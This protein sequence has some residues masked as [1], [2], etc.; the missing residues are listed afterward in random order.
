MSLRSVLPLL[1]L[2]ACAPSLYGGAA[3][4]DDDDSADDD[5][6]AGGFDDDD[7]D[8]EPNWFPVPFEIAWT[9]DILLADLAFDTLESEGYLHPFDHLWDL[10]AADFLIGNLEGPIT[11][12][13]DPYYPDQTWSYN[14]LPPAAGALA[15][16]GFDALSLANN[17]LMDRGP[18]GV[19]DTREHLLDAGL[20]PFGAGSN[21]EESSEPLLVSTP[22]GIVGV[23]GMCE[24]TAF[25]PQAGPLNTGAH[26]FSLSRIQRSWDKAIE[27]GADYVVA[28][29][30]WG[31]NYDV[32]ESVQRSRAQVF[33]DVGYDLVV[34]HGAHVPQEVD[35]VGDMVVLYSLG[36][37]T[38]GTPGRFDSAYPGYGLVA[39]TT[40]GVD[41]FESIEL[42]CIL[43]D[44]GRVHF[45]PEP[46]PIEEAE[47]VL[48][49]LGEFVEVDQGVGRVVP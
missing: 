27:A 30:H 40:L 48:A 43:T 12:I 4:D 2:T 47:A 22:F 25:V 23:V 3:A 35:I 33:A 18:A 7:D 11:T 17:H 20:E 16:F 46:C 26:T 36:N 41:G 24:L 37:F 49:G 42:H 19:A 6:G 21:A 8:G 44:N 28:F 31:N 15:D 32:V 13:S 1:L 29:V 9:G 10:T 34:G 14:A 38:F 45:Q 5:D 39:R